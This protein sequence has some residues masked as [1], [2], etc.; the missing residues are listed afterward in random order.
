M[1]LVIGKSPSHLPSYYLPSY[2]ISSRHKISSS[3]LLLSI[4]SLPEETMSV[5]ARSGVYHY[6]EHHRMLK[7]K[8]L[9]KVKRD[10][11]I[12]NNEKSNE[13]KF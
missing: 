9:G 2:H 3:L 1:V 8:V 6:G 10:R 11:F 5:W 7:K 13:E 12:K 4:R